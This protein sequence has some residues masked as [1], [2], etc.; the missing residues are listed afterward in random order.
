[1]SS[2]NKSVICEFVTKDAVDENICIGL[3]KL[4]KNPSTVLRPKNKGKLPKKVGTPRHM[5]NVNQICI[6]EVIANLVF[7]SLTSVAWLSGREFERLFLI[8]ITHKVVYV[9]L[10]FC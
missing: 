4:E 6:V 5:Q 7:H 1:A 9:F 8:K 2:P 10:C 3:W